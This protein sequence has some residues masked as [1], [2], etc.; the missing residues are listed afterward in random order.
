MFKIVVHCCE[1]KEYMVKSDC[2]KI[3]QINKI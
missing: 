1:N 3:N 2:V